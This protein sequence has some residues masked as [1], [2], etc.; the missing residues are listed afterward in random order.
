MIKIIGGVCGGVE[1]G[2]LSHQ[3]LTRL[4]FFFLLRAT[5][6]FLVLFGAKLSTGTINL[7]HYTVSII[8]RTCNQNE[9]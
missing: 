5:M 8:I 1:L 9:D 3:K 4:Q 2:G 7:M 6:C